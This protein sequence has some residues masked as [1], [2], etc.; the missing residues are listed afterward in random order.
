VTNGPRERAAVARLQDRRLD[1][2]EA[3][4]V[5]CPPDGRDHARAVMKT[6]RVSS[7]ISRS[8]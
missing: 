2:D 8:R 1:L 7:F 4:L 5:E 3:L 6:S